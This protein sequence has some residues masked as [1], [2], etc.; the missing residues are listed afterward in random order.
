[1]NATEKRTYISILIIAVIISSIMGG[2][3]GFFAADSV[4]RSQS[5]LDHFE[6]VLKE[7]FP[8]NNSQLSNTGEQASIIKVIEKSSPAVVSII[9]SKNLTKADSQIL[10]PDFLRQFMGDQFF[11]GSQGQDKQDN[12]K[13][14]IG[15]GSGFI[16]SSDGLVVTNKH[17]VEDADAEYTIVLTDGK[18]YAAKVLARDPLNDLAVLKIDADNLPT[19]PLGSSASL[20]PGQEVIAIGNAL[21]EFSNT[22]ST[23]VIS[24]LSRSITAFEG[25]GFDSEQLNGL[26]QTDAS[27]NPGNSGG[28]LLNTDG[29]VIGINVAVAQNAQNIGFAIPIDQVKNT[30]DNVRQNGRLIRAWLGVRYIVITPE[31][32]AAN[33]LSK[34][35]GA[36]V[37]RGIG[38]AQPAVIKNS[39]ADKAGILEKD[40]ILEAGGKKINEDDS[41]AKIVA[42]A[43]PGDHLKIKLLREGK[44]KEISILLEEI[45]Q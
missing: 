37:I 8:E 19:L 20:K 24:G 39:P 42:E 13:R 16:V 2:L 3:A 4:A 25:M 45:K 1:M 6:Q 18:K 27:I 7:R 35:Y 11:D 40:I 23:G 32:A 30:I 10:V 31:I 38:N 15:G 34:D 43:K 41:L 17:V 21:G 44:E 33:K 12:E 22:V 14:E 26:I 29:A 36:W 5:F 28:P 9:V